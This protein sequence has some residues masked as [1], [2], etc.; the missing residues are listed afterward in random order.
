MEASADLSVLYARYRQRLTRYFLVVLRDP[1]D[2][3][4]AVHQVFLKAHEGWSGY[5]GDGEPDA[6]LFRIARNYALDRQRCAGRLTVLDPAQLERP[7]EAEAPD[8]NPRLADW[9]A[10]SDIAALVAELPI[11]Q[12]RVLVLRYMLGCRHAE[13][14]RV[15]QISEGAVRQSHYAALHALAHGLAQGPQQA[16]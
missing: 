5:R 16:A 6:W 2:A 4:D 3:E 7:R 14:A 8:L 1:N 9:I 12:Q 10:R 11:A 15:L 13:T